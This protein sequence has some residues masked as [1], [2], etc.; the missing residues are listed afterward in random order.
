MDNAGYIDAVRRFGEP[1]IYFQG[2]YHHP[3]HP[4]IF[5]SSNIPRD[6]EKFGVAGTGRYWHTD[7]SFFDEPLP[8]TFIRPKVIPKTYRATYYIDMA[9]IW[10]E[11]P[12]HL[13]EIVDGTHCWHEAKWRYKVQHCD[14]DKSI[15]EILDEFSKEAPGAHHPTV[16]DHPVTRERILYISEGFTSAIEELNFHDSIDTLKVINE[17]VFRED[18]VHTHTWEEGD[19]IVWDNRLLVH[20]ASANLTGEP[21]VSYRI[22]CYDGHPFYSTVNDPPRGHESRQ[23]SRPLRRPWGSGVS[24][25]LPQSL[26]PAF[27]ASK[28]KRRGPVPTGLPEIIKRMYG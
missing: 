17:F 11:L 8:L 15:S 21:S 9:R 13:K 26:I 6:G 20:K 25:G 19:I 12:D 16:I 3:D 28:K 22:G 4:E 5:V 14:I 18:H 10:R 7:C 24:T 27:T 23:H 1:Q 2:N